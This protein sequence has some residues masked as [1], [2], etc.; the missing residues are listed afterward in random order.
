LFQVARP[1]ILSFYAVGQAT[2]SNT[3][4]ND[5]VIQRSVVVVIL[6][7]GFWRPTAHSAPD[8]VSLKLAACSLQLLADSSQLTAQGLTVTY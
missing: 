3:G 1:A 5:V 4:H 7:P 2:N 8:D 6:S